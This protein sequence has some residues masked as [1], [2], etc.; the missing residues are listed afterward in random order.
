M[1]G[2]NGPNMRILLVDDEDMVRELFRNV[3]TDA[4]YEVMG[5]TNGIEAL[6]ILEDQS[7]DLV[8]TDILMPEKEGVETITEI[9]QKYPDMRVIAISGG[10]RVKYFMPL[11][12]AAKAGADRALHKPIEPDDLLKAVREVMAA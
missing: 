4:G 12:I 2:Q 10:G 3:L 11:V 9:K 8:I 1:T 5:A 7:V 6:K